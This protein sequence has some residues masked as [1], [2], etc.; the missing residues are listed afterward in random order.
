[1]KKYKG[2]Q[3][4]N[5]MMEQVTKEETWMANKHMNKCSPALVIKNANWD[6]A[7]FSLIN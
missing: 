2:F 7:Q 1:M 5:D 6:R 3:W 4:E